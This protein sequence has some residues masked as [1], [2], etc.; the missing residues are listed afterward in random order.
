M[1]KYYLKKT[2]VKV[3]QEIPIDPKRIIVAKIDEDD[4]D[5][6]WLYYLEKVP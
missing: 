5:R 6:I 3:Y 1:V 4:D 2:I